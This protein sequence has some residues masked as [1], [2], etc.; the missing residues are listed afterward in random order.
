MSTSDPLI[1]LAS[2]VRVEAL[3][4]ENRFDIGVCFS[5]IDDGHQWALMKYVAHQQGD[6]E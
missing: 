5:A 4:D 1:V 6:I 3:P 2:V